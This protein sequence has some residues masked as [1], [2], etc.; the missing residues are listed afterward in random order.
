MGCLGGKAYH[1]PGPLCTFVLGILFAFEVHSHPSLPYSDPGRTTSP[2][3]PWPLTSSW[4]TPAGDQR[5]G[6]EWG[7]SVYFSRCP[8]PGFDVTVAAFHYLRPG[9]L[10]GSISP[11]AAALSP[12]GLELVSASHHCWH[13]GASPPPVGS[14]KPCCTFVNASY[15]V[16]F[17]LLL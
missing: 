8:I 2:R 10:L 11:L 15:C 14:I 13:R 5:A 7:G 4:E 9:L 1:I 12:S 6:G 17:L 3:L 16:H